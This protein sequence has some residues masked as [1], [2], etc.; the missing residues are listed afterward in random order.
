MSSTFEE[1]ITH[2]QPGGHLTVTGG[3]PSGPAAMFGWAIYDWA[4]NPYFILINIFV[5]APYFSSV[6]IGD[7]VK[8]QA[9]WGYIQAIAGIVIALL[10]PFFGSLAD[11]VGARKPGIF[12]FTVIAGMGMACLWFVV[13]GAPYALYITALCV[14]VAATSIEFSVVYHNAMLPTIVS[15]NRL[16]FS[17]GIGYSTGFAGAVV[18][19]I[20]W[21]MLFG[22]GETAAFGLDRELHEHNR[23]V[24]PL[25]AIWM[26]VFIIPLFLF[27]PDQPRTNRSRKEAVKHG[28]AT[29]VD[30]VK[31]LPYYRN[32]ATYLAARM[33]YYDG[34]SAVF[35]FA[36]VYAAGTF[37]WE[38]SQVGIYGLMTIAMQIPSALLGGLID[39]KIGSKKTIFI[40]VSLFALILLVLVGTTKDSFFLWTLS[41]D[42]IVATSTIGEWLNAAG[43]D[44]VAERIFAALGAL[45]GA[46]SG[47]S[48]SSSRTMLARLAPANMMAEFYGL[49]ALCGKATSFIA[50]TMV[51]LVTTWASSQR[52]GLASVLIMMVGGLIMLVYVKEEK[53]ISHKA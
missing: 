7:P 35:I 13:P 42:P 48:L 50:P 20:C 32:I 14:I 22:T 38:T 24:G 37:G 11:A 53:S 26:A 52:L 18:A 16:G 33:V 5:F 51:A 23:I 46:F 40:S 41:T 19:F 21:L 29:V 4:I 17:S 27:T 45:A 3:K 39:D 10:S 49:Y 9:S 36:G 31:Q 47:P 44:T 6:V 15:T 1:E 25:A 34:Q 8:G 12:A 2:E 28:I 30:T 43:F